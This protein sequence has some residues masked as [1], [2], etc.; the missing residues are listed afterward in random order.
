MWAP[1]G[2]VLPSRQVSSK[3]CSGYSGSALQ[4]PSLTMACVTMGQWK[5]WVV[6]VMR[7]LQN[8]VSVAQWSATDGH[9]NAVRDCCLCRNLLACSHSHVSCALLSSKQYLPTR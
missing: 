8:S 9:A 5:R 3:P 2:A 6:S 7:S 1:V 4:R